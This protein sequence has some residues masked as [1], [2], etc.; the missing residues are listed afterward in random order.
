MSLAE[1]INQLEKE[2][3]PFFSFEFFVPKT[4]SGHTKLLKRIEQLSKLNP[5][6]C[7]VTWRAHVASE[8]RGTME[9]ARHIQKEHNVTSVMHMT[10]LG[11]SKEEILYELE[12]AKK[13][14]IKNLFLLRGDAPQGVENWKP[15]CEDFKY[16][17][18]LIK[19]VR[20]HY[21]DYFCIGCSAY[22]EGHPTG[23]YEKDLKHLKEKADAGA[24]F[25]VSQFFYDVDAFDRFVKDA[26]KLGVKIPIIPG[27]MTL[28]DPKAFQRM[29]D[30]CKVKIDPKY[31]EM[32]NKVNKEGDDIEEFRKVG[33]E[34]VIDICKD[35]ISRGYKGLH[36]YTLNLSKSVTIVLKEL[37][38]LKDIPEKDLEAFTWL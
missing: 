20:E 26:R 23:G 21:G 14:G 18:D 27:I 13:N 25:V 19:F 38:Y 22:P 36:L 34:I 5:V 28:V 24:S 10:L 35:L 9:L 11:L 17:I 32:L 6:F 31:Q 12:N 7:D 30:F 33:Q 3:K 29:V 1:K 8:E 37:G 16:A 4:E 15:K 2:N